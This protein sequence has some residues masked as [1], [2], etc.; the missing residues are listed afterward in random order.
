MQCERNQEYSFNTT[1]SGLSCTNAF[2][3]ESKASSSGGDLC[4]SDESF[5]EVVFYGDYSGQMTI[6]W[7]GFDTVR[8]TPGKNTW[9]AGICAGP[10]RCEGTNSSW[11]RGN[12]GSL[13]VS[14]NPLVT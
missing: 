8:L 12:V 10:G 9:K 3:V 7:L 1:T 14:S 5:R 2:Y 13:W 4:E 11:S 6:Q